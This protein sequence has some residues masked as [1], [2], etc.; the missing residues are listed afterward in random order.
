[1]EVI[2]IQDIAKKISALDQNSMF[3][4]DCIAGAILAKQNLDA[5][6]GKPIE[7]EAG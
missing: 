1:M 6:A 3:I 2:T 7:K 5:Q 4:M